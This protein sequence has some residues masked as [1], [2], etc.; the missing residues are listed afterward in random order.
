MQAKS[1]P[2]SR[3]THPW[4]VAVA[5]RNG[6]NVRVFAWGSS[7]DLIRVAVFCRAV[8]AGCCVVY[9]ARHRY[10]PTAGEAQMEVRAQREEAVRSRMAARA[11]KWKEYAQQHDEELLQSRQK[12][13]KDRALRLMYACSTTALLC[14]GTLLT[15]PSPG[16]LR[17]LAGKKTETEADHTASFHRQSEGRLLPKACSPMLPRGAR[18]CSQRLQTGHA[19]PL[20]QGSCYGLWVCRRW[21]RLTR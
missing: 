2:Q 3:W 18:T 8:P 19:N 15:L 11:E 5:R 7:L 14:T 13:A 16:F 10:N 20:D 17:D 9:S 21:L 1:P 4:L 12:R 6:T